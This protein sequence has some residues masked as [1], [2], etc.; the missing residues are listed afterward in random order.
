VS[1]DSDYFGDVL[2]DVWLLGGN[3]DLID[4][5]TCQDDRYE[6][7]WPEESANRELR[8]QKPRRLDEECG[9]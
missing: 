1:K 9:G 4:R 3:P 7:L 2:Y 6:G 8:R 5:D